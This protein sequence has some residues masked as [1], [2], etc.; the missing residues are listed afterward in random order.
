[1]HGYVYGQDK[2]KMALVF[3]CGDKRRELCRL[4]SG[5]NAVSSDQYTI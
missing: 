4:L 5:H 2:D 3:K 1:M